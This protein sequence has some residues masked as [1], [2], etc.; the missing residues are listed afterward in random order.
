M[1][2]KWTQPHL[3]VKKMTMSKETVEDSQSVSAQKGQRLLGRVF[4]FIR[5]P[6]RHAWSATK[7]DSQSFHEFAT[8]NKGT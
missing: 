2:P 5:L 1:R 8:L 6:L 7:P 3:K 4:S